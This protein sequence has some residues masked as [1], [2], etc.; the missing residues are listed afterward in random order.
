MMKPSLV[1][2]DLPETS[3]Q[4]Q[5]VPQPMEWK[6]WL[7]TNYDC[8]Q[9]C[10]YC[11]AKSSPNAPRRALGVKNVQRLVDEA[12]KLGFT[13]VFITGGEPFILRDIYDMLDYASRRIKTT[14][15][16]TGILIKGKR[17]EQLNVIHREN[18]TLQIS[19]DGARPEQHDAY[20]GR[21]T[22]IQAV[23][24]IHR[25]QEQGYHV[26]LSTTETP[27]N[28]QHLGEICELHRSWGIPD[29]DHF[30]RPLARRGY[31]KEGLEL[32]MVNVSP[33]VTVNLDG[34][35]WH[36]LSTDA[37]MQISKTI[38]P[39]STAV[40]RIQEQLE[41]LSTGGTPMITFT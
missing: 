12:I 4:N 18:L 14:V 38:F 36:P 1:F 29:E 28:S 30:V 17:L 22:W 15:L 39:L 31:S 35:F 19:L 8:H 25:L 33:E 24:A 9:R 11:V 34:V 5:C 20:R 32:E 21:G 23:E 13:E 26:K 27:A 7:Y 3:Q 16:T 6:L 2:D 41:V 10:S 40:E 37:D